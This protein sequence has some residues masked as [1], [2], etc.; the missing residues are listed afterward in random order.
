M[1]PRCDNADEARELV[2]WAKFAPLGRRGLDSGNGDN[3]YCMMPVAPY[4]KEAND[5]TFLVVQIEDPKAL[6]QV[7]AIAEVEGVDVLFIGPGDF[8]V[9]AGHPGEFNHPV[10]LDAIARVAAAAKRSGKAWG[11]PT[12]S[13]E[14]TRE[15]LDQGAR[16]LAHGADIIMV[17]TALEAIQKN[18]GPLGF[19]FGGS[20]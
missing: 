2:S 6:D 15:L 13:P 14:R 7:E 9:L 3:P 20:Q 17:K 16:F 18:F 11:M 19:R 8:S 5:Q 12:P 4:V 1:Y 10:V